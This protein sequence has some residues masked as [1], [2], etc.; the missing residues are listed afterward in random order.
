MGRS[1]VLYIT[2]SVDGFIADAAGGIDWLQGAEGEDY[3]YAEFYASIGAVLM[4]SKTY[5]QVIGFDVEFPY[6][7]RPCYVFTG[8]TGLP[9]AADSV[10]L[11]SVDPV[12]FTRRLVEI[13]GKPL[14]AC[15]GAQLVTALWNDGL[16]DE[17]ALFV[18]PMV[19]GE[20]IPLLLPHHAQRRL[21]LGAARPLTGDLVEL[22]YTV[23]PA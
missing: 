4:G 19:L 18:Q 5:E 14:W 7:D 2:A 13:E 8:R 21:R 16:I 15:G 20:G 11:V 10:E 1:V 9:K 22:R 12:E 6:A 3:G 17:I 23:M